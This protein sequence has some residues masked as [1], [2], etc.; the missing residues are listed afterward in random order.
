M[1]L[2]LK[3]ANLFAGCGGE[4]LGFELTGC[5]LKPMS[6][7]R[8]MDRPEDYSKILECVGFAEFWKPA[9]EAHLD[10]FPNCKLMRNGDVTDITEGDL[11]EYIN[12]IFILSGGFPCQ[13]FSAAGKQ[14]GIE[15]PRGQLFEDFVRIASIIKP[16]Y[17]VGE[18]VP[19]LISSYYKGQPVAEIICKSFK[20]IG[21][22]MGYKI[23]CSSDYG[24]P[25]NRHRIIFIGSFD[26]NKYPIV[27]PEQK[28]FENGGKNLFG[29]YN[30]KKFT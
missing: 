16:K 15:D 5:D 10:N 11:K 1:K 20:E 21:Y 19:A 30:N 28:Y 24:V 12:D 3:C 17:I 29:N 25:Q 8:S 9:I 7:I 27:F 4:G 26:I 6:F 23:L 2:P 22:E 14:E 18:N 13:P